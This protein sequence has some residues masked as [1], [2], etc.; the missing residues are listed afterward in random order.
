MI[1]RFFYGV[2]QFEWTLG[3]STLSRLVVLHQIIGTRLI[4]AQSARQAL[5]VF[6][7][8]RQALQLGD[9]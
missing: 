5:L 6:Q 4:A 8:N 2:Y 7:F 1:V 3:E 9:A